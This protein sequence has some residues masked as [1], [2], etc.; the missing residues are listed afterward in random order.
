MPG[1]GAGLLV[2]AE[3][4][5]A[6]SCMSWSWWSSY[7]TSLGSV[8]SLTFSGGES[9]GPSSENSLW[10]ELVMALTLSKERACFSMSGEGEQRLCS[11]GDGGFSAEDIA[12]GGDRVPGPLVRGNS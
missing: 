12:H 4:S 6:M 1:R 8:L 2:K 9:W 10:R 11:C 3:R 7:G 5:F